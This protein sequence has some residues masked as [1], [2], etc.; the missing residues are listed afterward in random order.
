MDIESVFELVPARWARLGVGR[1]LKSPTGLRR[2][3]NPT[4]A[5]AAAGTLG[6][7]GSDGSDGSDGIAKAED[8]LKGERQGEGRRGREGGG[9]RFCGGF[10]MKTVVVIEKVSKN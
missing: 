5:A 4:I 1:G 6:A 8:G 9:P 7:A 2:S 10:G 3:A